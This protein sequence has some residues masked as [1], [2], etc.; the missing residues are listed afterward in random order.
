M[1][2]VGLECRGW[3]LED[4]CPGVLSWAG[5]RWVEGRTHLPP[6][7][8]EDSRLRACLRAYSLQVTQ[9]GRE[10]NGDQT[11]QTSP[12]SFLP[13]YPH[14]PPQTQLIDGP[15]HT[16]YTPAV[17]TKLQRVIGPFSPQEPL[18]FPCSPGRFSEPIATALI[19]RAPKPLWKPGIWNLDIWD[20]PWRP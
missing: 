1:W 15:C 2:L 14:S 13:L 20:I 19:S 10:E 5:W 18:P 4:G 6:Q 16:Y 3:A 7:L 11:L 9:R 12:A 8:R 17:C